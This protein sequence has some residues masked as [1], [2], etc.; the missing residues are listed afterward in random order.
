MYKRFFSNSFKKVQNKQTARQHG[1]IRFYT[2]SPL[3]LALTR[4]ENKNKIGERLIYVRDICFTLK[5]P[6]IF[7]DINNPAFLIVNTWRGDSL[8]PEPQSK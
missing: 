5:K 2:V 1:V 6:E 3:P 8:D 7:H 4:D